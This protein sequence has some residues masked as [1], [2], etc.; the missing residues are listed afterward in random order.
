MVSTDEAVLIF[1]KWADEYTPVLFRSHSLRFTHSI[2]CGLESASDGAI[3]LR[4]QD[5]GYIQL[6]IADFDFEYFDPESPG[7]KSSE[8]AA[9]QPSEPTSTGAGIIATHPSGDS[10]LLLEILFI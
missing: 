7:H 1:R 6:R 8:P 5:L 10:F 2:L 4:L 9:E 3:K